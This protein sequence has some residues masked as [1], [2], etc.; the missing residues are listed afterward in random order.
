MEY[1]QQKVSLRVGNEFRS[2]TANY[3]GK[4]IRGT[5]L[6]QIGSS[7]LLL[8]VV[9]VAAGVA[10]VDT[11]YGEKF[12]MKAEGTRNYI[13]VPYCTMDALRACDKHRNKY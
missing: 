5:R 8:F 10:L 7:T 3:S 13:L 12:A 2:F 11:N 1:G 6:N 9:Y 4:V